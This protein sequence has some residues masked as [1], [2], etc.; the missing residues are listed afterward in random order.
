MQVS[1][2]TGDERLES[3]EQ[4]EE[5]INKRGDKRWVQQWTVRGGGKG[6]TLFVRF[7]VYSHQRALLKNV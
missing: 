4:K 6:E 3:I 2:F 7:C 1:E 5:K